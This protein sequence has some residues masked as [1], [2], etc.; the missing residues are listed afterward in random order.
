MS[1]F[2]RDDDDRDDEMEDDE[3]S[4]T[5]WGRHPEESDEDYQDRIDDQ[6]SWMGGD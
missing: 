2:N 4:P 1:Y 5:S 6:V 3:Y